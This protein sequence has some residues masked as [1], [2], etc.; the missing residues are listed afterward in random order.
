[1][2]SA[3]WKACSDGHIESVH[4]LLKDASSIDIEIKGSTYL[5]FLPSFSPF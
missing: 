2:V 1:M 4:E 5:F 3:L